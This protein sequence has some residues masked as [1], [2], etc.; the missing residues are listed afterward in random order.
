MNKL[1]FIIVS[2]FLFLS[3]CSQ[4]DE[5]KG[6]IGKEK[7]AFQTSDFWKPVTDVRADIAIIYGTR[8]IGDKTFELRVKSWQ[9]RRYKTHFMTGIAWG[10]YRDYFYGEWDGNMHMDEGQVN[11]KGD[12]IWHGSVPYI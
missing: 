12:T 8:N 10:N 4:S 6:D 5:K 3:T 9:N 11:Q 2:I 7:T 1:T